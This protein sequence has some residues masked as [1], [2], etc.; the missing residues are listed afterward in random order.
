MADGQWIVS[1]SEDLTLCIWDSQ[2]AVRQCTIKGHEM[3]IWWV[4]ASPAGKYFASG[5]HD[6]RV[7]IWRCD[8][9]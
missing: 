3:D 4:D 6:C 8:Y 1:A 9:I 5:G 2:T 7:A